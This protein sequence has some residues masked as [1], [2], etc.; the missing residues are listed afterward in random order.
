ME[1]SLRLRRVLEQ[2]ILAAYRWEVALM[3]YRENVATCLHQSRVADMPK[4]AI[5]GPILDRWS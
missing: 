2:L 3:D 1:F 5:V 4:I